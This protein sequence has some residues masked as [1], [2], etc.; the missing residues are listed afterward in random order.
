MNL[1][2][3][4]HRTEDS[5]EEPASSC[6]P[7][8]V[9]F[10]RRFACGGAEVPRLPAVRGGE[11]C[12]A[13]IN[14]HPADRVFRH[15]RSSQGTPA[16]PQ[17]HFAY[18]TG[19][20]SGENKRFRALSVTSRGRASLA[21][22]GPRQSA[23]GRIAPAERRSRSRP[24]KGG[25][26]RQEPV[27]DLDRE[28]RSAYPTISVS[29]EPGGLGAMGGCVDARQHAKMRVP[30]PRRRAR[31]PRRELQGFR[32]RS[33][34]PKLNPRSTHRTLPCPPRRSRRSSSWP[35]GCSTPRTNSGPHPPCGGRTNIESR[36]GGRTLW[37]ALRCPGSAGKTAAR[38]E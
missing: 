3:L 24:P 15:L 5:P 13:F 16:V 11:L 21:V 23:I 22:W 1:M 17:M 28:P 6:V 25:G 19:T 26:Q 38:S 8:R 18:T 30:R 33:R 31:G 2:Q 37:R 29:T 35:A 32:L 4:L 7:H 14:A 20:Q 27:R 9:L 34:N 12:S 10:E 36:S